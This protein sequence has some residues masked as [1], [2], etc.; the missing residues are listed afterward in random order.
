[1][2]GMMLQALGEPQG[3]ALAAEIARRGILYEKISLVC[4]AAAGV[5]WLIAVLLWFGL[6]LP[7]EITEVWSVMRGKRRSV[8]RG[9][10]V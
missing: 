3:E 9:E 4:F 7:E 1:M 6:H 8:S 2:T 5:I 10:K